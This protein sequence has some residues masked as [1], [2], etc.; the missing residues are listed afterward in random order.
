MVLLGLA[1]IR[2]RYCLEQKPTSPEAS[3]LNFGAYRICCMVGDETGVAIGARL[4]GLSAMHKT[5][6]YK[7][8]QAYLN[9]YSSKAI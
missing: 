6:S 1:C 2:R 4:A 8:Y 9:A 7:T 5:M 3:T